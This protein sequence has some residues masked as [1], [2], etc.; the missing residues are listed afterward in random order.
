MIM[1]LRDDGIMR[2]RGKGIPLIPSSLHFVIFFLLALVIAA[3]TAHA[4]CSSPDGAAGTLIYNED[5]AVPQYCDGSQWVALAAPA[6][7][8]GCPNIG[9]LCTDGSYYIGQLSGNNIYATDAASQSSETWNNG[10]ANWTV[11]GFTSYTDGPGNTAGLVALGDAGSPYDA[12]EYCDGLTNVHGHSDWYLPARDELDLFWNGGSP[13][14]GVLTD[15]TFYWAST[16]GNDSDAWIQRFSN[17]SR[18]GDLKSDTRAVRCVRRAGYV[19]AGSTGDFTT[20]LVGHWELNETGNTSTATDAAGANDGT[21]TNFPADPTSRWIDGVRGGALDFVVSGTGYVDIGSSFDIE[22]SSFTVA[23][24]AKRFSTGGATRHIFVTGTPGGGPYDV[25]EFGYNESDSFVC[26]FWNDD[27]ITPQA[28]T[29]SDWHFWACTY[30]AATNERTIYRDGVEVVSDVAAGDFSGTGATYI[31]YNRYDT[32]YFEGQIDDVRV[33]D[34]ALS[35]DDVKALYLNSDKFC[36][37]PDGAP[38]QVQYNYGARSPVYCDGG[39]WVRLAPEVTGPTEGLVGW[40]KLDEIIGTTSLDVAGNNDGSLLG[41]MDAA[42]DHSSGMIAS[43]LNFDGTDDRIEIGNP[44]DGYLD[45]EA[46]LNFTLSAWINPDSVASQARIISK[47]HWGWS[48]GYAMWLVAGGGIGSGAAGG[49][50]A[51]SVASQTGNVITAGQWH[52]VVSVIN[53]IDKT[54]ITYV[55]GVAQTLSPRSGTCGTGGGTIFDWSAC[56]NMVAFSSHALNIGAS[57]TPGEFFDGRID[58]VRI[59]NRALTLAEITELYEIGADRGLLADPSLVAY[60]PLNESGGTMATDFAGDNLGTLEN[61]PIFQ[62][63]GGQIGGAVEFDGS[64]DVIQVANSAALEDFAELT[65]SA[66]IYPTAGGQSAGSRII[67]K[68]N[69]VIS[70]DYHLRISS[71]DRVWMRLTT[72]MGEV[73][74]SG[75]TILSPNNWYHIAGTWDGSFMRLYVDGAEDQTPTAQSGTINKSGTPLTLGAHNDSPTDRRFTGLID[76]A[77][78]YSRALTADEIDEI[79]QAGLLGLAA[80]DCTSPNGAEGMMIFNLDENAP[81]YCDGSQWVILGKT[82]PTLSINACTGTTMPPA[83]GEACTDGSIFAGDTNLYVTNINQ[84]IST[85]WKATAGNDDINPD[86]LSDGQANRTNITVPI[87]D[88]IAMNICETLSL[89]THS[90]WYLPSLDEATVL[91]TNRAAI[92]ASAAG[93]FDTAGF[94][95]SS[96]GDANQAHIAD[97]SGGSY[98]EGKTVGGYSVRCVRRGL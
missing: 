96:E 33:Y 66:W 19:V 88:L 43:A 87:V 60:W 6:L 27:L 7:P 76:D 63:T 3:P 73:G 69:G 98:L 8:A 62:S 85:Q 29:D 24:W 38:G 56:T 74:L 47:G 77:R 54:V 39:S 15:G 51:E 91:Y 16:E 86:S 68:S 5:Q 79:Y 78:I 67:S 97:F 75:T 93:P 57:H 20:G 21:L 46:G 80:Q 95:T 36:Q 48:D 50:Q 72:D 59:Y 83:I 10:T 1:R 49:T 90:D 28:Y 58:D 2:M 82:L 23:A 70:D 17:G 84:S 32:T 61:G 40:W 89:H 71:S 18:N 81:Q 11:T 42:N 30:D 44:A 12:A 92:D 52:H 34:R 31:G 45:F 41:G 14:A 22:D 53:Q 35:A 25:L 65:L 55:D 64:D 4:A 37:N 13:V 26:L 9:D 94:W